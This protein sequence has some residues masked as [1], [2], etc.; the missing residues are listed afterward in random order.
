MRKYRKKIILISILTIFVLL[1]SIRFVYPMIWI[2]KLNL[3]QLDLGKSLPDEFRIEK[4][5]VIDDNGYFC[6]NVL[7]NGKETRQLII[8]TQATCL[9]RIDTLEKLG[10]N[11]WDSY[12][13]NVRNLYGQKE[14]LPVYELESMSIDQLSFSKPLMKGFSEKNAIYQL[15]YKEVLGKDM[16]Q[17]LVWKFDLDDDK[18]IL[19]SNKNESLLN[20][21]S[22]D[23][24]LIED[25]LSRK[26]ISLSFPT[27][28]TD[29]YFTLDLGYQGEISIDEKLFKELSKNNIPLKCLN[30]NTDD[31]VDTTYVFNNIDVRWG[32]M[33]I[34]KCN[35]YHYPI[36][37][38]NQ[39]G[40]EFMRHF[41]F[42]LVYPNIDK[43]RKKDLY[44]KNRSTAK[45]INRNL[46]F[47]ASGF[48]VKY[49]KDELTIST[50]IQGSS[51]EKTGLKFKDRIIEIDHG[52]F[53]INEYSVSSGQ[54]YKYLSQQKSVLLK[55]KRGE[56]IK[57]FNIIF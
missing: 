35:L 47:L 3:R 43:R 33:T 49:T 2:S 25:G 27:I 9:A 12:P 53:E 20:S 56:E 1:I 57:N 45:Y 32:N 28:T 50:I 48:G 14:K 13:I 8:D 51:A 39:I 5:L 42:I 16:L 11:Y 24:Q 21:E 19:F 41:N 15:L 36:S 6:I 34:E 7:F 30:F 46:G 40:A 52:A 17:H 44:I 18:L 37:N 29:A 23:Y 38:L 31:T 55:I 54:I 22:R 26:T 4:Q 10:A